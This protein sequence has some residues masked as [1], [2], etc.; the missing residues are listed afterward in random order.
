KMRRAEDYVRAADMALY[1]AKRTGRGCFRF[2][3][4]ELDIQLRRRDRLERDLR[5]ALQSPRHVA[6]HYQPQV[7]ATGEMTGVEA[8]FRWT[9][10]E[11]GEISAAEAIEI[12]EES[13]LIDL[14]GDFVLKEAAAFARAHPQL[15][16]AVNLS[17]AQ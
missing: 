15:S 7:D 14:L 6:V 12:A 8:L 3:S 17:P 9:H 2:F 4:D 5:R 10:P 11:L 16:V 13:D 1:E